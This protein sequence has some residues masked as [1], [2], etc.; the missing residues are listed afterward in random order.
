LGLI[1]SKSGGN[2]ILL[3]EDLKEKIMERAG[4]YLS[5]IKRATDWLFERTGR[6]VAD[7]ITELEQLSID[8]P[9]GSRRTDFR[10]LKN[11]LKKMKSEN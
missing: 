1:R 9:I 6:D 5:D 10:I 8:E 4:P 2:Q 7:I 11:T 3:T